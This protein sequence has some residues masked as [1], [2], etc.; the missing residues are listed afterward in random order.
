MVIAFKIQYVILGVIFLSLISN[1]MIMP[2]ETRSSYN[3]I[4]SI[5]YPKGS[6]KILSLINE[7]PE[8]QKN[9]VMFLKNATQKFKEID[10]SVS[11]ALVDNAEFNTTVNICIQ[12]LNAVF[13]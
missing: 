1:P 10:I 7:N 8:E 13:F 4:H 5:V 11:C 2:K 12:S 9:I 6:I 3:L